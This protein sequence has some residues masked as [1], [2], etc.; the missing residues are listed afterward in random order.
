VT[1]Q[2]N[3]LPT[4]HPWPGNACRWSIVDVTAELQDIFSTEPQTWSSAAMRRFV[5]DLPNE[6]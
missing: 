3:A 5:E 1:Y 2:P 4:A 6:R